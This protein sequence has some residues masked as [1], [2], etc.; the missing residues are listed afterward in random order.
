MHPSATCAEIRRLSR[1]IADHHEEA[2][3]WNGE[4]ADDSYIMADAVALRLFRLRAECDKR[5]WRK[6][7]ER[8]TAGLVGTS[9]HG[10]GDFC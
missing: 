7:A 5:G 9:Y 1:S 6:C 3:C 8:A 4:K 10:R 2:R